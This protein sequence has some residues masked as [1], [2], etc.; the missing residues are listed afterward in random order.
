[1][2]GPV[3][4]GQAA[5]GGDGGEARVQCA[6]RPIGGPGDEEIAAVQCF[7]VGYLDACGEFDMWRYAVEVVVSVAYSVTVSVGKDVVTAVCSH[8]LPSHGQQSFISCRG[9]VSW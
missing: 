6:R 5:A 8:S 2:Q 4:L 1:G 9:S 3:N 7:G